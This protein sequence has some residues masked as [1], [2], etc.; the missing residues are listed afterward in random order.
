M[1]LLFDSVD[2]LMPLYDA[3]KMHWL[4]QQLPKFAKIIVSTLKENYPI[5]ENLETKYK[6]NV[7]G[8]LEVKEL[9]NEVGL[10][11]IRRWLERSNRRISDQQRDVVKEVLKQ[12]SLPLFARIAVDQIKQ[13]HS[14]DKPTKDDLKSTVQGAI[15]QL[16]EQMELKFGLTLV[17]HSLSYLTAA[18]HGL[19]E[20]ELEHMLSLD[21]VL[22]NEIFNLWCPPIRR[23]PP[24]L[25][26]RVRFDINAYVV[27]RSADNL[28]VLHWYHRQFIE[29]ARNRYLADAE[30]KKYVHESW[31]NIF[32]G[33]GEV[34]KRSLSSSQNRR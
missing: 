32:P 4:P 5:L 10:I 26:T 11:V 21:D 9:E 31:W 13:W 28:I 7:D 18:R 1:L 24:L 34:G 8:F 23:V 14:Y 6:S 30:F 3:Y 29:T 15:N 25:W 33:N 22:L 19:S 16:F 27:E 2:Q 17:K 12:C 20:V